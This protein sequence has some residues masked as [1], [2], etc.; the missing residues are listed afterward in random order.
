[1]LA[2]FKRRLKRELGFPSGNGFWDK[3]NVGRRR[4]ELRRSFNIQMRVRYVANQTH[5]IIYC[6]INKNASTFFKKMLIEH[7]ECQHE[8]QESGLE[9]HRFLTQ[10]KK[11]R[12]ANKGQIRDSSFLRFVIVREPVE[13]ILSA[14]LNKFVTYT[15]AGAKRA[16]EQYAALTQ[17]AVEP[18]RL[19]TFRQ[20]VDFIGTQADADL[21]NHWRSQISFLSQVIECFDWIVP[22]NRIDDF[23]PI[24]ERRM[25][26]KLPSEKTLNSN[27]YRSF[28][29]ERQMYDCYPDQLRELCNGE[30]YPDKASLL[31]PQLTES[32]T[33]RFQSDVAL[34][35]LACQ[36]FE[37]KIGGVKQLH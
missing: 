6:P 5:K 21:D 31:T 22:M 19:M 25:A 29:L 28:G 36:H 27:V 17:A 24:L 11:L 23:I 18:N 33:K 3:L 26:V 13:R 37:L 10:R 35:Q 8:W 7:G 32:L 20:F 16:A 1:M 30:S 4:Q 15:Y 9:V 2:L 12:L 14:Y 34:Y